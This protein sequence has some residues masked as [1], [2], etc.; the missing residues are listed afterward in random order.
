MIAIQGSGGL[1]II[2]TEKQAA[3]HS[4]FYTFHICHIRQF[5]MRSYFTT[6]MLTV[7]SA[8]KKIPSASWS[9]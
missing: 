1:I 2:H 7:P 6:S 3:K 8:E 5:Y 4:L 9:V